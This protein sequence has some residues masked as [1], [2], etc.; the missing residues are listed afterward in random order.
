MKVTVATTHELSIDTGETRTFFGKVDFDNTVMLTLP[1]LGED[2]VVETGWL[3][4]HNL[5]ALR[6]LVS[7]AIRILDATD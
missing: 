4:R 6:L 2:G 7:R 1:A 3:T 5:L